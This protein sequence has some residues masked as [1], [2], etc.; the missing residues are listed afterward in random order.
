MLL[1][2]YVSKRMK[3]GLHTGQ[4]A[5]SS[6]ASSLMSIASSRVYNVTS[7]GDSNL[8]LLEAAELTR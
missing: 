8:H 2:V 5:M 7:A 6:V 3:V 4:L 1:M